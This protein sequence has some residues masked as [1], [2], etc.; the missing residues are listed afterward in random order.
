ME[1]RGEEIAVSGHRRERPRMTRLGH[2][3][4]RDRQ[5]VAAAQ[6]DRLAVHDLVVGADL[7]ALLDPLVGPCLTLVRTGGVR[8]LDLRWLTP[9][10]V[11]SL[12]AATERA[13]RVLVV[14]EG[15][16]SGGV[17]E[18]VA[19]GAT[20]VPSSTGSSSGSRRRVS[21]WPR[22]TAT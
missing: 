1:L 5:R 6:V 16:K 18:S 11:A 12:V 17:G 8:V 2:R 9:L 13:R 7:I 15:R 22:R 10:P 4:V 19:V 14:D 20:G 3:V 21:D